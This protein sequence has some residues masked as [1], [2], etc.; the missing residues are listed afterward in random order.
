MFDR[1]HKLKGFKV[2]WIC[3][4]IIFSQEKIRTM[5]KGLPFRIK[6][7]MNS[8]NEHYAEQF[9]FIDFLFVFVFIDF[10]FPK[11]LGDC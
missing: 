4:S 7:P 2:Y 10:F 3:I 1:R 9:V 5:F 8:S 6:G 11:F